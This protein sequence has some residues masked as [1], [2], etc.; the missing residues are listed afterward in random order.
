MMCP[1]NACL[2]LDEERPD[3]QE[4]SALAAKFCADNNCENGHER[5]NR[6]CAEYMLAQKHLILQQLNSLHRSAARCQI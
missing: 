4:I 3:E 6:L 1:T 2:R 5:E